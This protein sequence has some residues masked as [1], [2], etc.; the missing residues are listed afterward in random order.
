MP[1]EKMYTNQLII[2]T[3]G[4]IKDSVTSKLPPQMPSERESGTGSCLLQNFLYLHSFACFYDFIL[5]LFAS[6][7]Y[8]RKLIAS[9]KCPS[10]HGTFWS[11]ECTPGSV[12]P[13]CSPKIVGIFK[14]KIYR[15]F[16]GPNAWVLNLK[17]KK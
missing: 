4:L 17:K 14:N 9:Y 7:E 11:P 15:N 13:V 12:V 16:I 5:F 10:L 8:Q 3:L 1:S 2:L 6:G